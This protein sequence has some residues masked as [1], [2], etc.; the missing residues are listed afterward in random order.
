MAFVDQ[1]EH[2]GGQVTIIA[3]VERGIELIDDGRDNGRLVLR[4]EL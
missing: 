3:H 2:V 1:Q 4:D